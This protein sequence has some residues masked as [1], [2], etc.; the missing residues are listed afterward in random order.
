MKR[1]SPWVIAVLVAA[2]LFVAIGWRPEAV[3]APAADAVASDT[4]RS[5][6]A[7]M[8][9]PARNETPAFVT[10]VENLPASLQGTEVDGAL[11]ADADGHLKINN[12]VRRTFDYFLSAL[13][14]EPLDTIVVRLRAYIRA[15]LPATAAAEAEKLLAMVTTVLEKR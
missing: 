11:E 4:S 14:E 5:I 7:Q 10:G 1:A 13:G 9:A 8:F 12:A 6:S 2:G 3:P 15:Q